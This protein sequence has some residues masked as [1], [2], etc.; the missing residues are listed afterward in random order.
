LIP[1][2][3]AQL[4][5]PPS[6]TQCPEGKHDLKLKQLVDVKFKLERG[7]TLINDCYQC[8]VCAKTLKNGYDGTEEGTLRKREISQ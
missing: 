2:A 7:D 3:T 8:H 5:P 6:C 1:S 4:T